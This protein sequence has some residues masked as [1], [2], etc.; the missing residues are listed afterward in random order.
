MSFIRGIGLR[1]GISGLLVFFLLLDLV[2][3]DLEADFLNSGIVN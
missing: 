1:G 3:D 2:P